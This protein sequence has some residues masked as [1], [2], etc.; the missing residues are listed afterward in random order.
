MRTGA[1]GVQTQRTEARSHRRNNVPVK[2][3]K[4]PVTLKNS[5]FSN[6]GDSSREKGGTQ[7]FLTVHSQM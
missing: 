6:A 4:A 3:G 1:H 5:S 7:E 2:K